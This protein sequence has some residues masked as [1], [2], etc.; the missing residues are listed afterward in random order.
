M[1]ERVRGLFARLRLA[2]QDPSLPGTFASRAKSV[3]LAVDHARRVEHLL[4]PDDR[5]ACMAAINAAEAY[6][7]A[8]TEENATA[9]V[10]AT[11]RA[12]WPHVAKGPAADAAAS[13]GM[14]AA[15]AAHGDDIE[16]VDRAA[17]YTAWAAAKADGK[18]DAAAHAASESAPD[19]L[20]RRPS[21][22]AP[23]PAPRPAPTEP[24]C[25]VPKTTGRDRGRPCRHR[26]SREGERCP[27]HRR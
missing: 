9:V 6:A 4:R 26:V 25:G 1:S 20:S 16:H 14:T 24:R 15:R 2:P 17:E 8:P 27:Q 18:S 19:A 10:D 13:A 23:L 5:Q 22:S 7:D 21:H 12:R 11:R 3:R